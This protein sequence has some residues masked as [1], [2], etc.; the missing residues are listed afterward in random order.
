[1]ERTF[2]PWLQDLS[3]YAQ[4]LFYCTYL[5]WKYFLN[6]Q[7]NLCLVVCFPGINGF[8]LLF[9][10]RA[11]IATII[12]WRNTF[13]HPFKVNVKVVVN[14]LLLYA[15]S[16]LKYFYCLSVCR[17]GDGDS[18]LSLRGD[19]ARHGRRASSSAGNSPLSP[20]KFR[21][22]L[23]QSSES[24]RRER[25]RGIRSDWDKLSLQDLW[26][27][28]NRSRWLHS[29]RSGKSVEED[30]S[31]QIQLA[32]TNWASR[33]AEVDDRRLNSP[34]PSSK[35]QQPATPQHAL[36]ESWN[37]LHTFNLKQRGRLTV[38]DPHPSK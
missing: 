34:A 29:L 24:I 15:I 28:P 25:L 2:P 13:W 31:D 8:I 30:R 9:Q 12:C 5:P 27:K 3:R 11:S 23:R 18:F 17:Y 37:V 22:D 16:Y 36:E 35:P 38:L 14:W 1:M 10:S 32:R 20:N 6:Y 33:S 4:I 21:G 7:Q 19:S 26:D